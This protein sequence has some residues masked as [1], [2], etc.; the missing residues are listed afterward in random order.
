MKKHFYTL[1]IQQCNHGLD[2]LVL[3]TKIRDFKIID[4]YYSNSNSLRCVSSDLCQPIWYSCRNNI[5]KYAYI[6]IK[7]SAVPVMHPLIL[8]LSLLLRVSDGV[9]CLATAAGKN[10]WSQIDIDNY[11]PSYR[12][13]SVTIADL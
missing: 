10:M 11:W 2:M 8:S 6:L 3:A 5:Y 4:I 12:Y 1:I 9:I 13:F 7:Y